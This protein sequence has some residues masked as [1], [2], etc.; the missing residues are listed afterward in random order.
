MGDLTTKHCQAC[1][2]GEGKLDEARVRDLLKEVPGW[3]VKGAELVRV[4]KFKDYH[5]TMAFVNATAWI[6]HGEDHHP[7]MEVGYNKVVMRYSTHSAG[8]ITENDYIC[9]AKVNELMDEGPAL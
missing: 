8:G 3:E 2:S 5:E 9:A 6:S 1:T 4:F 7:D